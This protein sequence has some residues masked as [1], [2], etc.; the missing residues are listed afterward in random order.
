VPVQQALRELANEGLVTLAPN[1]GARV[2]RLDLSELVDIYRARE[3]IEPMVLEES[4]AHISDESIRGIDALVVD[5]EAC[6]ARGDRLG[7]VECDRPLHFAMFAGANMPR[8]IEMINGF[9]DTTQH[10]RRFYGLVPTTVETSVIEH[11][12]LLGLIAEGN[13]EDAASLLRIHIRR[14]RLGLAQRAELLEG[15]WTEA[16][17]GSHAREGSE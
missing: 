3:A 13:A 10:Y 17:N 11:R 14:T 2:A 1:F 7:Y 6:A 5:T 15:Q 12:L 4:V 16:S 9:W 8:L